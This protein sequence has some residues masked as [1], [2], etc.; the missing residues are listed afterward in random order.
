MEHLLAKIRSET[1]KYSSKMKKSH[2]LYTKKL[3]S[4]IESLESDPSPDNWDELAKCKDELKEAR[5]KELEGLKIRTRMSWLVDGENPS[6]YLSALEKK[7]FIDKTIKKLKKD[8]GSVITDQGTILQ[9]VE[10]S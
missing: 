6:K 8:D 9:E 7:H 10:V 5:N 1:I 3:M 2:Q 4:R